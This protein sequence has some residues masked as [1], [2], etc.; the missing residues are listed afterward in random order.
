MDFQG[1]QGLRFPHV[2]ESPGIRSPGIFS[3]ETLE[4]AAVLATVKVGLGEAGVCGRAGATA[5][6]DGV[7][8]RRRDVRAGRGEGTAAGSNKGTDRKQPSCQ[9][10]GDPHVA[11]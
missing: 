5:D 1:F 4:S 10:E 8:A 6:L 7:C 9:G 3:P 11:C 2:V